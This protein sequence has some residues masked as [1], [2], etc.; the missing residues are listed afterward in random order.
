MCCWI[1]AKHM[2]VNMCTYTLEF[3]TYYLRLST[4][5]TTL[6][7]S[8]PPRA[9]Q[10]GSRRPPRSP[11]KHPEKAHIKH[12]FFSILLRFSDVSSFFIYS[13]FFAFSCHCKQ[14]Q[15]NPPEED[16][17]GGPQRRPKGRHSEEAPRGGST[18]ALDMCFVGASWRA[19]GGPPAGSL[20]G[21][22][23]H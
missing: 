10:G 6:F 23:G 12:F 20:G 19:P 14:P 4:V 2:C 17:R 18:Y 22:R 16:P 8:M 7:P 5:F 3:T 13:V 9:P 11:Q 15:E 1:C 21:P